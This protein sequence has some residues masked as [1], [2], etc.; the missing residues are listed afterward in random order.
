MHDYSH[1]F[2]VVFYYLLMCMCLCAYV[3]GTLKGKKEGAADFLKLDLLVPV[4][5]YTWGLGTKPQPSART[6]GVLNC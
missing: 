1:L 4:S 6:A 5:H 2:Q 3:L